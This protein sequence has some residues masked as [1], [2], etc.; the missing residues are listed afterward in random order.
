MS[1]AA[2][3]HG[4]TTVVPHT[5][6]SDSGPPECVHMSSTANS[7]SAVL[8]TA[9]VRPPT[10]TAT[11]DPMARSVLRATWMK[12]PMDKLLERPRYATVPPPGTGEPM[13]TRPKFALACALA[14]V[15]LFA[16]GCA[17]TP[18]LD[19]ARVIGLPPAFD[20]GA[21]IWPS[22]QRFEYRRSIFGRDDQGRWYATGE[23]HMGEHTG[24]HVDAPLHLAEGLR[25]T[26]DVP[27]R[28]L[29]G[30]I[31]VVDIAGE[32]KRDSNYAATV[33][34]LARHE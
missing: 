33:A 16:F 21:I 10:S 2:P 7:C 3:C 29:I 32:C 14:A 6:P 5:S 8:K 11:A 20:D 31:R 4:H 18:V 1:N 25:S 12:A 19:E 28:Q 24:T 23:L 30:P 9:T 13:P 17:E 22:T 15:P 26:A 27:L 34:D